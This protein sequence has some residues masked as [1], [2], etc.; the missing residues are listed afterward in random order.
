[1]SL[2]RWKALHD[3]IASGLTRGAIIDERTGDA[4]AVELVHAEGDRLLAVLPAGQREWAPEHKVR[5]ELPRD[6]SVVYL[7]GRVRQHQLNGRGAEVEVTLDA[8]EDRQRRMDVR[9]DAEC[10]VRVGADGVWEET[11]TVNLSVGGLL[12]VSEL[13]AATGE[14]IDLE[15]EIE[16]IRIKGKAEVV[17]RGV[18]T[19]GVASR[20]S[21]ALR[22]VGL[23]EEQ[24]GR[25]ALFVLHAQAVEKL[26]R[27]R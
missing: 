27:R 6:Q 16:G 10:R 2:D 1:M 5:I 21:A 19:H 11:R 14:Q 3:A 25:I 8:A 23:S 18:K 22:F 13:E 26:R 24:R 17:R 9:V 12:V 4:H 7:P 20:T 15:L